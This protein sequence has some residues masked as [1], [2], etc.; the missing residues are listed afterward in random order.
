MNLI[1]RRDRLPRDPHAVHERAVGGTEIFG[2]DLTASQRKLC[3]AVGYLQSVQRNIVA[4][5]AAYGQRSL[6]GKAECPNKL[7]FRSSAERTVPASSRATIVLE[8]SCSGWAAAEDDAAG[9]G[10]AAVVS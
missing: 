6:F 2:K 4:R 7:R 1:G 5:I 9:W 3:V 10:L 8:K